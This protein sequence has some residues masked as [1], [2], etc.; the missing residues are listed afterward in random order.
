MAVVTMPKLGLTMN[1]GTVS[2]WRKKVGDPVEKGEILLIVATD[3][4]TFEV[5]AGESGIL[6]EIIVKQGESAVVSAPLARIGDGEDLAPES[7]AKPDSHAVEKDSDQH[8]LPEAASFAGRKRVA[9][10]GGGPGGYVAAIRAAQLGA[11]VTLIEK[12]A[13]GGVCLNVGC[14]PTK[15]LLHTAEAYTLAKEGAVIGLKAENVSVDWDELMARKRAVVDTLVAGVGTLM[16]SNGITVVS[17]TASF[18]SPVELSVA[19]NEGGTTTVR[20][21]S[22]IIS[23]GSEPVVPPIPGFELEGV[24]TSTEALSLEKIPESVVLVGGGVIGMEFASL[25]SS[26]GVKVTVVEM[27]PGILPMLD[28]EIVGILRGVLERK[29]VVFHTSSKVTGVEKKGT[30]FSVSVETPRGAMMLEAEKVL[31]SVGRKPVTN[32]VGLEKIGLAMERSRIKTDK[33]METSVKGVYAVGDCTSPIMLAHVASREGEV[34]AENIMGHKTEMDYKTVPNAVYTAP[35][36]A[37]VG[38]TEKEAAEKGFRVKIGR[39]PFMANGKSLIMNDT[40]G[41]VKYVVDE[42][43]DEIL[44]VHIIGPRATDLIV[45]GALALRLE[46]TVDELVTTVHA[47]PT[48]GEA[49]LEGALAVRG[50]SI[51]MPKKA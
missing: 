5:E 3:K 34:A 8:G 18:I 47:H 51:S 43:Y 46:A 24:M 27:L 1:E 12:N 16:N 33:K 50:Q 25:F 40:D 2:E 17:G 31:V 44:G 22:V 39:F 30:G 45:E 35:E 36:I 38:L 15:V 48:V 37:S 23:T 10:I 26:F 7:G 49:L 20:A 14:I 11:E 4:L 42:K 32:G 9:V 19:L 29:G 41:L 6:S 21:D 28:G 13:L